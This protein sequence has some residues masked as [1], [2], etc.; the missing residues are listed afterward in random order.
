MREEFGG[1]TTSEQLSPNIARPFSQ[2][3]LRCKKLTELGAA[4]RQLQQHLDQCQSFSAILD[5]TQ[6]QQSHPSRFMH[7]TGSC[8]NRVRTIAKSGKPNASAMT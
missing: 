5:C 8:A 6:Q 1:W 3:D 2:W 7:T 4:V